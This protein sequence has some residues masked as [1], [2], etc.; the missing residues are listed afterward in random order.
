MRQPREPLRLR[1]QHQILIYESIDTPRK[2]VSLAQAMARIE[3]PVIA[4]ITIPKDEKKKIATAVKLR[5]QITHFEF[6]LSEE[7]A[8]A[9][10]SAAG[11]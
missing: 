2:T 7:Y 9:K 1:R 5:N 3:N 10:F 4:G 8:M 11:G 6:E